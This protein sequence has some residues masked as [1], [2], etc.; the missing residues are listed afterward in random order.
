ML[1]LTEPASTLTQYLAGDLE[2]ALPIR[3]EETTLPPGRAG[4]VLVVGGWG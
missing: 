3:R 1:P 4:R 2:A